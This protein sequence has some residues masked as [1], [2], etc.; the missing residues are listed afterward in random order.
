VA[1]MS[2][3]VVLATPRRTVGAAV[4]SRLWILATVLTSLVIALL[5]LLWDHRYFFR[6]DTQTAYSGWWY[7]LGNQVLHGR[8]PLLNPAAWESGNYVAEGQW[9]LFSPLTILIGV[10]VRLAPNVV[11]FVTLLKLALIVVGA[12]GTYLLLRSYR[13]VPAAAYVGGVLVGLS[14]QSVI[15]DWPAWVNGQMATVLLPWAWWFTRRAMRGRNP[16]PALFV[17]YLIV[18]IGYVYAALYLAIVIVACLVDGAVAR[19]RAAIV[20]A[21]GIGAFSALVVVTVY[22]P[23]IRTAPVTVRSDWAISSVGAY[24]VDVSQIFTSML[25]TTNEFYLL[26]CLPLVLWIDPAR[27][28]IVLRELRG[29]LVGTLIVLAWVLGP[30]KVGPLRWPGRVQP[31][32]MVVLVVLLVVLVSRSIRIPGRLRVMASLAWLLAATWVVMSRDW[33]SRGTTLIGTAVVAASIVVVAWS[34]RRRN[35]VAALAIGA[36]TLAVFVTQHAVTPDTVALDRHSP[37]RADGYRVQLPAARG[38]VMVIGDYGAQ[39]VTRPGLAKELLVG[40]TWYRN[41]ATVQNGYSTIRFRA[42]VA[43]F[44]RRYNGVTCPGALKA[45]LAHEATT[46]RPWVDLLSISTLVMYRPDFKAASL[47][48]PPAGWT[49]AGTTRW[50]VTWVRIHPVPTAGAVVATSAGVRISEQHG[51]SRSV[52]FRVDRVPAAGGS[53]VFSRLDWPGYEVSG[54]SLAAPTA[55]MLVTVRL[56][57]SSAGRSVTVDWSP[58]GWGSEVAAWWLAVLGGL[59]WSAAVAVLRMR[60]RRRVSGGSDQI[61]EDDAPVEPPSRGRREYQ[62]DDV[63]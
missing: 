15:V 8:I 24:T 29:A 6:G 27:A 23:G 32:L 16:M 37:A 46:G 1:A 42:F 33:E 12:L 56:D 25:P 34:L 30:A 2:S 55:K 63:G 40:S 9:G 61:V 5:P 11:A 4:A 28:R 59:A 51:D 58:P 62:P 19:D 36:C 47:D 17:C 39:S 21:L 57:P 22:L 13:V 14:G 18:S 60:N 3:A 38:D 7:E 20:R 48:R 53:V 44:C 26:W 49:I 43:R 45:V 35:A 50:T 41:P 54:A 31:A 52:R 10:G